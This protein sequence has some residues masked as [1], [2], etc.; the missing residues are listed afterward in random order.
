MFGIGSVRDALAYLAGQLRALGDT[1]GEANQGLRAR[2]QLDG[3]AEAPQ[4]P[5]EVIDQAEEPTANG[6]GRKR[7]KQTV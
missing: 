2:L 7:S 6:R 4:L 5:G 3:P 1:V